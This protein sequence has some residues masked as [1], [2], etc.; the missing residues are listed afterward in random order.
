MML[1]L[2][3]LSM[4]MLYA[5]MAQ[6][7]PLRRRWQ[8]RMPAALLFVALSSLLKL[9]WGMFGWQSF[10]IRL[11]AVPLL[12]VLMPLWLF[13]GPAWKRLVI[14]LL[15]YSS[16]MLGEAVSVL[17][18]I[19]LEVMESA[20]VFFLHMSTSQL[21]L[22]GALSLGTS[23]IMD[24]VIAALARS[25]TARRFSPIY[26]PVLFLPLCLWGMLM[27]HYLNFDSWI[28]LL[29]ILL[30]GGA[31]VI[32]MYC[33]VSLEEKDALKE[34]V[35][36]LRHAMELEQAYYRTIE[37]RREELARIRHDFNNQLSAI[38]RLVAGGELEDARQMVSLL[39]ENIAATRETPYC[40]IPVVNAVLEEKARLCRERGVGLRVELEMPEELGVEP[41]HLCSIFSNLIDNAIRGA[42]ASGLDR[43]EVALTARAGGDY[44]FIKTVNPGPEPAAGK[45]AAP[46]NGRGYGVRICENIAGRYGGAYQR[47][48]RDGL[49]TALVSLLA[50]GTGG[51]A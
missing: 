40:G 16:Q 17:L 50:A 8:W 15:L 29:C 34:R 22:Y 48:Y 3:V 43:P 46:A 4:V 14:N 41:L 35:R 25:F 6:V 31:T 13:Q 26:L 10:L 47:S 49:Y 38:G 32:L 37:E 28:W 33:I 19:P 51:P 23:L 42:E 11:A 20:E 21:L 7:L 5:F 2:P 36:E 44:L 12:L 18:L 45:N 9:Y 39:K 24:C 30:G 27:G 1:F